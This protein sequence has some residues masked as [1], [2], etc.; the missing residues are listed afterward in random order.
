MR[1]ILQSLHGYK[2]LQLPTSLQYI[3]LVHYAHHNGA[4]HNGEEAKKDL[5]FFSMLKKF[6]TITV[7]IQFTIL[8]DNLS[9]DSNPLQV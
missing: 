6:Q 2:S 5:F 7:V 8:F 4:R 9:P 3:P 1:D